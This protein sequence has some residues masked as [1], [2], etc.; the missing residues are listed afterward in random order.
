MKIACRISA[1]LLCIYAVECACAEQKGASVY[2]ANC[3]PCHG[4]VGDANT[5][6]GK[7][8]SV[9]PFHGSDA[10]KKSDAEMVEFIK[11]G[12]GDMP[13]WSD[14]LSDDEVKSVIAYIRALEKSDSAGSST[15]ANSAD[16]GKSKP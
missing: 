2:K 6:A 3:T 11:T 1:I 14:I 16:A 9:P 13:A 7:K 5:P 8:Y 10:F 4:S 12:K 15:A